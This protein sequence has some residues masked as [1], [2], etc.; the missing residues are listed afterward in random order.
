MQS[1]R[2]MG[3]ERCGATTEVQTNGQVSGHWNLE[4]QICRLS[5]DTMASTHSEVSTRRELLF[6][7]SGFKMSRVDIGAKST[8]KSVRPA[9]RTE[10]CLCYQA[11]S[12]CLADTIRAPFTATEF[13]DR[14]TSYGATESSQSPAQTWKSQMEAET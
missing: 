2:L 11:T 13:T 3:R 7:G 4:Y 10:R 8:D 1:Q 9:A 12:S 5:E 6:L 14:S